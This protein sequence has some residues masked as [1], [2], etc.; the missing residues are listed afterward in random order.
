LRRVGRLFGLV[1]IEAALLFGTDLGG[2]DGQRPKFSR[3]PLRPT[4]STRS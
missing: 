1:E 3:R 4:V 2:H